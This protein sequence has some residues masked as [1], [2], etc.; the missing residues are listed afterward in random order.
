MIL[1]SDSYL[2]L[3][4]RLF[5]GGLD[6]GPCISNADC[7]EAVCCHRAETRPDQTAATDRIRLPP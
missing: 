7:E 2:F 1:L 6:P 5:A 3:V 4:F